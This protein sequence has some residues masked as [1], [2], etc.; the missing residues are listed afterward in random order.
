MTDRGV[1]AFLGDSVK[2]GAN[3]GIAAGPLGAGASAATANLSA[4]II[5][6]SRAKGLYGGIS[7]DGAVVATRDAWNSAYYGEAVS[8]ADILKRRAVKNPEARTL[9]ETV[10]KVAGGN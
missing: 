7:V 10:A 6:F 3:V 2:L 1:A 8:L 9:V 4:D 5:S